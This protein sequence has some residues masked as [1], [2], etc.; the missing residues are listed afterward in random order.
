MT[1]VSFHF[2]VPDRTEYTCRLLRKAT[3]QGAKVVV[4]GPGD[5]LSGLDRALW[6]F[7]PLEFIPH[8]MLRANQAAATCL[9]ETP[10]WL[11][12]DASVS[13]HHDVLLNLGHEAP[14][15]FESFARLIEIVTTDEEDRVA[16]RSRWKHYDSRGYT[17]VRHEVKA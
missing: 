11:L 9:H 8:V 3:R 15:G 2:N 14:A 1:E 17:I 16:A 6:T 4:T 5:V 13:L 12:E 7:D 10:V